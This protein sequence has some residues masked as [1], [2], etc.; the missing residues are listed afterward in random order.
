MKVLLPVKIENLQENL[1]FYLL[2]CLLAVF[3]LKTE[4]ISVMECPA[5]D[6]TIWKVLIGLENN[7]GIFKG[8]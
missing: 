3:P 2:K 7:T 1:K 6:L 8:D 4:S 5:F